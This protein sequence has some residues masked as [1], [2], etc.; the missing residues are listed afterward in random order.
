MAQVLPF[1]I[2]SQKI[3][4]S[5]S[6]GRGAEGGGTWPEGGRGPFGSKGGRGPASGVGVGV[7]LLVWG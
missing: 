6:Q 3:A 2:L 4:S 7:P 1:L 5:D